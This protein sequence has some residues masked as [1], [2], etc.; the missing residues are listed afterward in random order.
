MP[1]PVAAE[2]RP[3]IDGVAS[4]RLAMTCTIGV[5]EKWKKSTNTVTPRIDTSAGLAGRARNPSATVERN[6]GR[7]PGGVSVAARG[8]DGTRH[9]MATATTSPPT[10]T[11]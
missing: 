10:T 8:G 6:D 2:I 9:M 4:T 3:V 5:N 7:P 11:K 1:R